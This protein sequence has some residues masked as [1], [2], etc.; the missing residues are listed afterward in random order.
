MVFVV[1]AVVIVVV[2][3]VVAVVA[4]RQLVLPSQKVGKSVLS[5]SI[6]LTY[7]KCIFLLVDSKQT[8]KHCKY[9]QW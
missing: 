5:V 8:T 2:V 3:D 6:L 7:C 4:V 1:V 9:H